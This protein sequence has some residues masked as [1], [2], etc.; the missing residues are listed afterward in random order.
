MMDMGR[1]PFL[2]FGWGCSA[3]VFIFF[4]IRIWSGEQV[5]IVNSTLDV[6]YFIKMKLY[7][8]VNFIKISQGK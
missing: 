3:E 5:F 1:P 4:I 2:T 6:A 8:T 7:V